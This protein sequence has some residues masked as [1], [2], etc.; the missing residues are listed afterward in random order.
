MGR[1]G[2]HLL[3]RG[4]LKQG[5][6]KTHWA[7]LKAQH[8]LSPTGFVQLRDRTSPARAPSAAPRGRGAEVLLCFELA[9]GD[10]FAQN[11]TALFNLLLNAAR[12][13]QTAQVLKQYCLMNAKGGTTL[14]PPSPVKD[15]SAQ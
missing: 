14:L 9:K 1:G 6:L 10:L 7:G 3:G 15:C 5:R 8:L 4:S 13:A 11:S 12:A 2:A